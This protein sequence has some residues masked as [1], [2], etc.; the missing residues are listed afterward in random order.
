MPRAA[1]GSHKGFG[2]GVYR[3]LTVA[4]Y[5]IRLLEGIH[6]AGQPLRVR[7][8]NQTLSQS[9]PPPSGAEEPGSRGMGQSWAAHGAAH[10][11]VC[12]CVCV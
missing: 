7:L 4:Q 10:A 9:Q 5:A 12:V 3:S 1:D 11:P 6:L 8:S 2:F